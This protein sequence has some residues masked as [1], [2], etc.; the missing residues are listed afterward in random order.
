MP[1]AL[2]AAAP[3]VSVALQSGTVGIV[4][5]LLP[6]RPKAIALVLSGDG[7]WRPE[8]ASGRTAAALAARGVAA[9]GVDVNQV[10]AAMKPSAPRPYDLGGALVQVAAKVRMRFAI[11]GPLILSGYSAGATLAYAAYVQGPPG[12][13]Q[14]LVTEGFCPDQESP[15]PVGDARGRTL[16]RRLPGDAG[17]LY[18]PARLPARWAL[19]EGSREHGCVGRGPA[20]FT[21]TLRGARVWT[22]T[23]MSHGFGPQ[24]A[25]LPALDAAL[26]WAGPR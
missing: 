9:V 20:A 26:D 25:F 12:R 18:P 17:W 11:R 7:G 15:R 5:T 14:A 13:F 8:E 2:P 6:P 22:V 10:L 24:S 23:G 19:V 21:A 1:P 3:V 4:H 16:G